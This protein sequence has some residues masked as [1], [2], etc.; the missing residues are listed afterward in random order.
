MNSAEAIIR[1]IISI[2]KKLIRM[3]LSKLSEMA[4]YRVIS[5]LEIQIAAYGNKWNE[6]GWKKFAQRNYAKID[7]LCPP[8]NSN[9]SKKLYEII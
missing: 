8:N 6:E 4:C 1:K 2:R 9:L 5:E 7:F 3:K